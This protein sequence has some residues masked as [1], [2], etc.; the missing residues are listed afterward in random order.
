M[1]DQDAELSLS[2]LPGKGKNKGTLS[3]ALP[4]GDGFTDKIDLADAAE[5]VRFVKALCKGR[6]GID[7]KAVAAELERLA[8]EVAAKAGESGEGRRSQADVLLALAVGLDLFHAPGNGG[9]GEAFASFT[10]NGHK[11]TWAI[12]SGGF[13]SWLARLYHAETGRVPCAQALQ[14]TLGVLAGK[15]QYDGPERPL[16]VRLTEHQGPIYLDLC[17]P[18]WRAVQ[19]DADG[20]RVVA[21]PPVRFVRRRGMLAL[22]EPVGGGSVKELRPLVNL[23]DDDAWI[24][25]VAWLLSA[26][27]P[28]GRSPFSRSMENRGPQSQHC[29]GWAAA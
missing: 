1:A 26:L 15:A 25:F 29:A 6:K 23:P 18:D 20:W 10:S 13:R 2:Y 11:E 19:I 8:G 5:R 14:D 22:P 12:R 28:A 9:D 16:A 24:L 21:D 17:D 3:A 7:R 4:N 27:R